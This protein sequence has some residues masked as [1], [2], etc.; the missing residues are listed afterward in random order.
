[1]L[2]G[3]NERRGRT[4]GQDQA[5]SLLTHTPVEPYLHPLSLS[6]FLGR[7]ALTCL[8]ELVMGS[9]PVREGS[10][11]GPRGAPPC[12]SLFLPHPLPT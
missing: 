3:G 8:D 5:V 2:Q 11:K 9:S 7:R 4:Q 10:W 1:M 6:C 12:P